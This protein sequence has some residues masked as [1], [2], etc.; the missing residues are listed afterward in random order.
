[1]STKKKATKRSKR[2]RHTVGQHLDNI[3]ALLLDLVSRVN[4][5]E[6][7]SVSRAWMVWREQVDHDLKALQD[8]LGLREK[9]LVNHVERLDAHQDALAKLDNLRSVD[10]TRLRELEKALNHVEN[11]AEDAQHRISMQIVQMPERERKL[12]NVIVALANPVP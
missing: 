9:L 5:L 6:S 2:S 1:M 8:R 3:D 4:S 11:M 10:D 7:V 12:L